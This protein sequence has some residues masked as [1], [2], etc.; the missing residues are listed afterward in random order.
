LVKGHAAGTISDVEYSQ[1]L[2][3][4]YVAK[5]RQDLNGKASDAKAALT[6]AGLPIP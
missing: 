2:L 1:K 6:A 4:F 5:F 3:K